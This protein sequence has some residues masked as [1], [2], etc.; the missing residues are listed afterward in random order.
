MKLHC[1]ADL[2]DEPGEEPWAEEVHEE[3]L[4]AGGLVDFKQSKKNMYLKPITLPWLLTLA[5]GPIDILYISEVA[6]V[7]ALNKQVWG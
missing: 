5:P 4:E 7:C 2:G 6:M 3:P 1:Q